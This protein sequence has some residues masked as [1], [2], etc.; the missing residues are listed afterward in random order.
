MALERQGGGVDKPNPFNF[1]PDWIED[2]RQ[3]CVKMADMLADI[4]LNRGM[5]I[6][7]NSFETIDQALSKFLQEPTCPNAREL[8]KKY[9]RL[10]W[11]RESWRWLYDPDII[12]DEIT[13]DDIDTIC[14]GE[15]PWR[16]F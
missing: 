16:S 4:I 10:N 12:S 14:R 8:I 5:Y 13:D 3:Y 15:Y 1:P 2:D 6:S 9:Y 7:H 11:E